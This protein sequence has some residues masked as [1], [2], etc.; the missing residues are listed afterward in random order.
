VAELRAALESSQAVAAAKP[1]A[2]ELLRVKGELTAIKAGFE[3]RSGDLADARAAIAKHQSE[4][5]QL[6]TELVAAQ[7][8]IAEKDAAF[9]AQAKR[10]QADQ[11]AAEIANAGNETT[12]A[13]QIDQLRSEL[14]AAQT[15]SVSKDSAFAE[16]SERLRGELS[17]A[18]AALLRIDSEMV[19]LKK[20]SAQSEDRWRR[21]SIDALAK[22][23]GEW[24]KSSAKALA[25]AETTAREWQSQCNDLESQLRS[26]EAVLAD[27]R[28]RSAKG[29]TPHDE[30]ADVA[31]LR[32]QLCA[33]QVKFAER[34]G[35]LEDLRMM[36]AG[37]RRLVEEDHIVLRTNRM[38]GAADEELPTTK[39][40]REFA[41]SMVVFAIVTILGIL[42]M[43]RLESFLPYGWQYGIDSSIADLRTSLGMD[44]PVVV[45]ATPAAT[46]PAKTAAVPQAIV[47]RTAKLHAGPKASESV[48]AT[49]QRDAEV[50]VLE[51]SGNWTR[52]RSTNKDGKPA[53]GWVFSSFLQDVV[54]D[55][56]SAK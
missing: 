1:D 13:A 55:K 23:K 27:I 18:K 22:A 24:G 42:Y 50:D 38:I 40:A 52:V 6:R 47:I 41:V 14:A 35:E 16:Q 49:L 33:L 56:A 53:E 37:N 26:S 46:A 20:N 32:E 12:S 8:A 28:R 29:D 10:Q 44:A 2:D 30:S 15:A 25:K 43:P 45:A 7:S 17:A 9:A 11:L 34:E 48:S 54:D 31:D 5:E 19:E 51:H 4:N 21:Q 3:T 36:P 39:R